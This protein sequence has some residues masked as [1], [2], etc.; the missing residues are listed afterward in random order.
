MKTNGVENKL[1]F[2][3]DAATNR[4]N[5]NLLN[6]MGQHNFQNAAMMGYL[7]KR[8]ER[9]F[10]DWS[11]KFCV[12]TNVGLLYYENIKERP[13]NLFPI[14]GSKIIAIDSKVY[15]KPFVFKIDAVKDVIIFAAKTLADYNNWMDAFK[16]LQEEWEEKKK[17]LDSEQHITEMI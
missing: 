10:R 7:D 11:D 15:N 4:T 9:W 14:I 16:N 8:A 17:T 1:N 3:K 13:H 6:V 2:N 5:E 12:L